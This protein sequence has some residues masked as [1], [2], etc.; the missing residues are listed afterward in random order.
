M[1]GRAD[2]AAD[3]LS[4]LVADVARLCGAKGAQISCGTTVLARAGEQAPAII[5]TEILGIGAD[6][7]ELRLLDKTPRELTPAERG[8]LRGLTAALRRALE[9]DPR[10]PPQI[11]AAWVKDHVAL[12]LDYVEE[13]F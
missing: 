6:S 13:A 9:L 11:N 4:W 2:P 12:S 7:F 5:A 10:L 3:Q 8:A 1:D